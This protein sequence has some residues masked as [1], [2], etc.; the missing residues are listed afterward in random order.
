M[1][2]ANITSVVEKGTSFGTKSLL[3][4]A[5][6]HSSA[7]SSSLERGLFGREALPAPRGGPAQTAPR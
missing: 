3:S 4:R 1:P 5:D 2:M 7:T 6:P